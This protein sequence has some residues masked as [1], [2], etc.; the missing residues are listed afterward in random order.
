MLVE[1][2]TP[3][4]AP[5]GLYF[6]HAEQEFFSLQSHAVRLFERDAGHGAHVDGERALVE[7]WEEAAALVHEDAD[8]QQQ[9]GSRGG[10]Y[11]ATV[12]QRPLQDAL[13]T[14]L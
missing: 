5:H 14:G 10:K 9:E 8:G 2:R 6:R 12:S 7:G 1:F 4:L 3:R 13:V 11:R